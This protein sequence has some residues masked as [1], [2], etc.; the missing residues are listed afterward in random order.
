MAIG[1]IDL[2]DCSDEERISFINKQIDIEQYKISAEIELKRQKLMLQMQQ[3]QAQPSPSIN[4]T[5]DEYD[6]WNR[7]RNENKNMRHDNDIDFKFK[8]GDWVQL[9]VLFFPFISVSLGK[10]KDRQT[11][12]NITPI[13]IFKREYYDI[14]PWVN[15]T[16]VTTGSTIRFPAWRLKIDKSRILEHKLRGKETP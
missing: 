8:I 14:E 12:Q 11:V 13:W 5:Q 4:I 6:Q 1:K 3:A 15:I 16:D 2:A 10:I 9:K 7:E